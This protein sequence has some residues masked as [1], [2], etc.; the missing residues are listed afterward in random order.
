MVIHSNRDDSEAQ[1]K[2]LDDLDAN[3]CRQKLLCTFPDSPETVVI[4]VVCASVCQSWSS[5]CHIVGN[6]ICAFAQKNFMV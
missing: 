3:V 4:C 1:K 5:L 2:Y 6:A